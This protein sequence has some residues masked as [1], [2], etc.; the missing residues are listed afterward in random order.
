MLTPIFEQGVFV[1][2]AK[3]TSDLEDLFECVNIIYGERVKQQGTNEQQKAA[4]SGSNHNL[5][6]EL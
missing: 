1:L 5:T 6:L 3:L 2:K 4:Q